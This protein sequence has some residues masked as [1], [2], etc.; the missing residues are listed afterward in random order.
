MIFLHLRYLSYWRNMK[1][2]LFYVSAMYCFPCLVYEVP[3]SF[4]ECFS[5]LVQV[6]F[7]YTRSGALSSPLSCKPK[8]R[9]FINC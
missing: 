5:F 2:T 8:C 6:A 3:L 1:T 4:L 9:M 7:M